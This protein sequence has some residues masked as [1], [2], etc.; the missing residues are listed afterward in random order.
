MTKLSRYLGIS[1][2]TTSVAHPQSNASL[3]RSHARLAEIIRATDSELE[4][5]RDWASKLKMASYCYNTTVHQATGYSPH[6]LMFGQPPRLI[7][8]VYQDPYFDTVENYAAKFQATH[9]TIWKQA[10]ASI[11]DAKKKAIER[12]MQSKPKRTVEEF[13][14]G[15]LILIETRVFKGKTNRTA[16]TWLGPYQIAG[17]GEHTVTIKKR[18]RETV[19]N[20]SNC[21]PYL[22]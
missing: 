19:V 22:C 20:K 15:Q 16:E 21:K 8:S 4:V 18:N 13:K 11:L 2:I 17:V 5:D 10:R 1:R 9:N 3:E 12:D 14:P 7:S 6:H